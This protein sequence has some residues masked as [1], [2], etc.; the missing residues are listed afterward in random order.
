MTLWY[1]RPVQYFASS[2]EINDGR[3]GIA[4]GLVP[5][6]VSFPPIITLPTLHTQLSPCGIS[7]Q[8]TRYHILS[9]EFRASSMAGRWLITR[10][11]LI[12]HAVSPCADTSFNDHQTS[13]ENN[14]F[15]YN[16]PATHFSFPTYSLHTFASFLLFSFKIVNSVTFLSSTCYYFVTILDITTG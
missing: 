11:S 15:S 10:T 13:V 2:Y 14:F 6:I 5:R 12:P 9:V 3:N 16:H 8:T 1:K 7:N 4:S